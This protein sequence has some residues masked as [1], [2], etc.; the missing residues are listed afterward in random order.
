[1]EHALGK[2]NNRWGFTRQDQRQAIETD[3][4]PS[5]PTLVV[6]HNPLNETVEQRRERLAKQTGTSRRLW[7]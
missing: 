5:G 4:R 2:D 7:K 1:M 3:R 6:L